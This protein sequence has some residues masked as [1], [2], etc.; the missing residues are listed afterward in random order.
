MGRRPMLEVFEPAPAGPGHMSGP[1]PGPLA[2]DAVE[3][4]RLATYEKGYSAGWEDAVASQTDDQRRLHEDLAG[5]LRALAC[6]YREARAHLLQGL[7]PLFRGMVE[8]ILPA[9]AHDTLG[10]LVVETLTAE[11]EGL[12]EAPAIV[13]VAPADRVA[14]ETAL[15]SD[16]AFPVSL[17]ETATLDPGQVRFRFGETETVL[18]LDALVSTI[19]RLVADFLSS[20]SDTD[21]EE[22]QILH[23]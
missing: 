1:L 16:P 9:I 14:V 21:I 11:A 2:P 10:A 17:C 23:G 15:G 19:G 12:A 22:R 8:R 4:L 3:D 7:E 18:D 6:T 13:E 20:R 5:N